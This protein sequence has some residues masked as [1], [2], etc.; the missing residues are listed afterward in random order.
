MITNDLTKIQDLEGRSLIFRS[1][2]LQSRLALID[3]AKRE[4]DT[5]N[6]DGSAMLMH[7]EMY[8]ADRLAY[9]LFPPPFR[10]AI[11]LQYSMEI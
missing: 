7:A 1:G 9:T 8:L 3:M 10:S 6:M 11:P 2:D 5:G 4:Y